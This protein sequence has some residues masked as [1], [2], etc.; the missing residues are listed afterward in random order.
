MN[1]T[2][3]KKVGF[4]DPI[5]WTKT[6]GSSLYDSDDSDTDSSDSNS[7]EILQVETDFISR[8]KKY[9]TTS[10]KTTISTNGSCPENSQLPTSPPSGYSA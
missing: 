9:C 2:K 8:K 5:G 6:V 1:Y 10:I 4:D 7:N 3:I